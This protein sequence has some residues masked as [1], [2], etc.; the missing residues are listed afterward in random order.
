MPR[1]HVMADTTDP[2]KPNAC[3]ALRL[4]SPFSHPV[5]TDTF[6]VSVG[7]GLPGDPVDLVV[8]Q[9]FGRMDD[10]P[11][12]IEDLLF[13]LHTRRTPILYDID[14]NLL[15]QHPDAAS[16]RAIVPRRRN[17]R[18]L[19]REARH[20]TVSTPFLADRVRALNPAVTLLPN[21]LDERLL[22]PH[23]PPPAG[24]PLTI[25]YFGTFTHLRDLMSVAAP[26]R[27]V[28]AR[29]PGQVTLQFCGISQ[30]MRI[31]SLFENLAKVEVLPATG[32]Y[33]SFL[34][35][36]LQRV[37][38][39]IGLAP[40]ATGAFEATKS[41]IK[42]LEYAAFGIAGIYSAHPA[43]QAVRPGVTGMV[44]APEDW[45]PLLFALATDAELRA[46]IVKA[47]R[48]YLFEERILSRSC[49]ALAAVLHQVIGDVS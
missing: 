47:S 34:D 12:T 13:A 32:D 3:A 29:L 14:D 31:L 25:G 11:A 17:V 16:E 44:G 42:F 9:R 8:M 23:R 21:A 10:T 1:V 20:I 2:D 48:D 38:W 27:A 15:D 46:S 30:D 33:G 7:A 19:L 4:V 35:M 6:D 28:L 36:M 26:L 43:Y 39:D 40:L 24:E 22:P 18:L 5:I 49:S 37:R 45:E 41:D